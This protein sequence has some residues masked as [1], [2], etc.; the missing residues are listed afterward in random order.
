MM[1]S[2]PTC[3]ANDFFSTTLSRHPRGEVTPPISRTALHGIAASSSS[4]SLVRPSVRRSAST[5]TILFMPKAC[6][7]IASPRS[8]V[9]W[10]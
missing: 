6:A 4:T 2:L 9:M 5:L 8:A 7:A 3:E 1:E 10:A